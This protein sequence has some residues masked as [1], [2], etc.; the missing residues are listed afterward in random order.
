[1]HDKTKR[2]FGLYNGE[3]YN[4]KEIRKELLSFGSSFKTKSD[5]EVILEA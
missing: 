5:T 2:F 4:Y 1:M 3:I